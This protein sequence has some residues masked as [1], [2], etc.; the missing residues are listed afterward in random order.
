MSTRV[1]IHERVHE[2]FV[3][4]DNNCSM[5]VL[6]ILGEVF[7]TPIPP[8]VIAAAGVM[9]GAGGVDGLCGLFSGVLMFLGVWGA[10]QGLHRSSVKPIS[11]DFMQRATRHFGSSACG[12]LRSHEEGCA[13]LA[14][15]FLG[16]A[17][18]YLR[19]ALKR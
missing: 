4:G 1:L 9:P 3:E 16:F 8:E 10:R 14:E 11:Q 7:E 13:P 17:I 5:T 19:D 15:E 2:Y 18:P 12:D 6:R